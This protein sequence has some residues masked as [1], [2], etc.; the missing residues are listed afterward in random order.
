MS[1]MLDERYAKKIEVKEGIDQSAKGA[2][3]ADPFPAPAIRRIQTPDQGRTIWLR[4][5]APVV[6]GDPRGKPHTCCLALVID[7]GELGCGHVPEICSTHTYTCLEAGAG[8]R[9][10]STRQGPAGLFL[11][12]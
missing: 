7:R 9:C 1:P 3:R 2:D 4:F 8:R 6:R 10:C 11:L 5:P 12:D